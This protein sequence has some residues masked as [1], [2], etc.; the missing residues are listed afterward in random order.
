MKLIKNKFLNKIKKNYLLILIIILGT[1]LRFYGLSFESFWL[2]ETATAVAVRDYTSLE[3]IKNSVLTGNVRPEYYIIETINDLPFYFTSLD[4][5]SELFGVSEFSLRFFSAIFGTLSIFM[6]FLVAKE[7]TNRKVA[8]LSTLIFSLSMTNIQFSQEARVYSFLT[9]I[10]LSSIYF[11]IRSLKTGKL[12]YLSVYAILNI[13]GLNSHFVFIFFVFFQ[14]LYILLMFK[15]YPKYAKRVL[16]ALFIVG[17]FYLPWIPR[18]LEQNASAG[19]GTYLGKPSFTTLVKVWVGFN[20]WIY[21]SM[22]LKENINSKDFLNFSIYDWVLISSI[23]LLVTIISIFFVIGITKKLFKNQPFIEKKWMIL[24]IL[25]FLIPFLSE[26]ILSIIHPTATLFGV[27]RYLIYIIPAYIILAS[28]GIM[29]INK[30]YT[31]AIVILLI[32]LSVPTLTSYYVNFDKGQWRE[33]IL[34]MKENLKDDDI[35][36]VHAPNTEQP[37]YYYYGKS[38]ILYPTYNVSH[39]SKIAGNSNSIWLVLSFDKYTDPSGSIKNYFDRNYELKQNKKL[40]NIK[41]F[42]Y[43]KD[44]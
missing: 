28:I 19:T 9:F 17:L 20:T 41:I 42:N 18:L 10:A 5:W 7:L 14:G 31:P 35:I 16:I 12:V 2:D 34:F 37:F 1:F 38:D 40:F 21:P 23:I 3:I 24:L 29:S 11:L 27:I 8:L 13:I 43:C 44:C 39:A 33:A 4:L 25:W 32:I 26:L 30:K 22:N 15:F 6:I 36:L